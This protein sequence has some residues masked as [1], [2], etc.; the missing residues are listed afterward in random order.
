MFT[1]MQGGV[2]VTLS[3]TWQR[4]RQ[5]RQE[6]AGRTTLGARNIVPTYTSTQL[7]S[8]TASKKRCFRFDERCNVSTKKNCSNRRINRKSEARE[9]NLHFFLSVINDVDFLMRC[10]WISWIDIFLGTTEKRDSDMTVTWAE[11]RTDNE[12]DDMGS[13]TSHTKASITLRCSQKC[14]KYAVE[15]GVGACTAFR[16]RA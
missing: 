5:K 6:F 1:V 8:E 14:R 10:N 11:W 3:T 13:P 15:E 2:P 7:V 9:N 4:I 16:I 12:V